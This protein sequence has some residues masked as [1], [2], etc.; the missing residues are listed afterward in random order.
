M[1]NFLTRVELHGA[2]HGDGSYDT[3]HAEMAKRG[4]LRTIPTAD[5]LR[6][7]P[8][9]EYFYSGSSSAK[10][11]WTSAKAAANATGNTSEVISAEMASYYTDAPV[12]GA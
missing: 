5:R 7:L 10:N 8:T 2:K 6:K 4:F 9:A 1:A 12:A 3:L 11:V